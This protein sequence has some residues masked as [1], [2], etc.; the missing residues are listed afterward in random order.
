MNILLDPNVA[1]V[2]LIGGLLLAILALFSPGTGII[3]IGALFLLVVAGFGIAQFNI[4]WWALLILAVGVFPFLLALRRSRQYIYLAIA[5]AALVIGSVFLIVDSSGAPAVNPFLAGMLSMAVSIF[6]WFGSRS[7]LKALDLP[8]ASLN[9][10]IGKEGEARTDIFARGTVEIEGEEWSGRSRTFIP[11][12][13]RVRVLT[14][15]GLTLL[16][17]P[18]E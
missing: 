1:Y 15:D 9:D 12:G 7:V 4:N 6:V 17:E 10:L 18:L 2:I 14:R 8:V 16:V 13:S 5:L 3:E 11:A